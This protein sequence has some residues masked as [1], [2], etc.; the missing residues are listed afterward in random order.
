MSGGFNTSGL[1]YYIEPS[2]Y[3]KS[4]LL[5]WINEC[6]LCRL[7]YDLD[8]HWSDRGDDTQS[9]GYDGHKYWYA[10]GRDGSDT[11]GLNLEILAD[12]GESQSISIDH[13]QA[14][15]PLNAQTAS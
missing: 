5:E 12:W 6:S 8:R 14:D 13:R 2:E 15:I 11:N 3:N 9:L 1:E 10:C 7:A 4:V